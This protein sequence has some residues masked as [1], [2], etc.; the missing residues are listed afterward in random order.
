LPP[1]AAA[2]SQL[3]NRPNSLAWCASCQL[4]RHRRHR[5]CVGVARPFARPRS[6]RLCIASDH[7]APWRSGAHSG[8][9]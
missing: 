8:S 1:A 7:P 6:R 4:E 5:T 2:L 9:L 3:A